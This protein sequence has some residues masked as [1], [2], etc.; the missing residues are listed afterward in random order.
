VT[1]KAKLYYSV[2]GNG[3]PVIVIHGGPGLDCY[4]LEAALDPLSANYSLYFFDQRSLGRSEG[5]PSPE[6]TTMQKLLQ[7]IE[8]LQTQLDLGPVHLLGHSWGSL[9][10]L[11]YAIHRPSHVNSLIL[12]SPVPVTY[13]EA[14]EVQQRALSRLSGNDYDRLAKI[15]SSE[16]FL[17]GD[18]DAVNLFMGLWFKAF[19]A[20]DKAAE[21]D[22]ALTKRT[23][24][25]WSRF[26]TLILRDLGHFDL[27]SKLSSI[28]CPCRLI[29]GDE[30]VVT[31][32]MVKKI[33]QH[34]PQAMLHRMKDCGHFPF[35]EKP[36]AFFDLTYK[37]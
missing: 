32:E 15:A 19:A 1:E 20:P 28:E 23:A 5:V 25:N 24:K 22:F 8:L 18:T 21:I 34:V 37:I 31:L 6:S 29:H 9:V 11:Y 33:Q 10:A 30:D 12:I 4:Y 17:L 7:D 36:D 26:Q 13:H 35:W 14:L 2:K 3:E 27:S 16:E